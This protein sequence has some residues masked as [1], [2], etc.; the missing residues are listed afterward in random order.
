MPTSDIERLNSNTPSCQTEVYIMWN[1]GF[2]SRDIA[3]VVMQ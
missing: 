2:K 1:Y 3:Q